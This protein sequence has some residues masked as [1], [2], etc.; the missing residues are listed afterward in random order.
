MDVHISKVIH[1]VTNIASIKSN[2]SILEI[3]GPPDLVNKDSDPKKLKKILEDD[4]II[5]DLRTNPNSIYRNTLK[6]SDIILLINFCLFPNK[7]L[8]K[9]SKTDKRYPYYSSLLL[10]SQAGLLFNKSVKDL[11]KSNDMENKEE[12][13]NNYLKDDKNENLKKNNISCDK[14]E[15]EILNKS[16]ELYNYSNFGQLNEDFFDQNNL[17]NSMEQ[18]EVF[19]E[20]F[21]SFKKEYEN[22]IDEK[23]VNISDTDIQKYSICPKQITQYDEDE[24]EIIN[25][26]LDAIFKILD[27]KD[28]LEE[29]YWGYFQTL[30]NY[31]LNNDSNIIIEYLFREPNL[32]IKKFYKH[33]N[34]IAVK[35]IM[36]NIL[37]IICDNEEKEKDISNSKYNIIIKDLLNELDD[38]E[39][40]LGKFEV[41]CELITNTLINNSE[42]QLIKLIFND[43]LMSIFEKIINKIINNGN[44]EKLR[45]ILKLLCQLNNIILNSFNESPYFKNNIN[46]IDISINEPIKTNNYEYQYYSKKI[47]S[48]KNIFNAY[49]CNI[50]SYLCSLNNLFNLIKDDIINRR[51]ESKNLNK[52]N[53][54][55]SINYNKPNK[56]FGLTNLCECKFIL[57][58]LKL[59]IYSFYSIEKFDKQNIK[60]FNNKKIYKNFINYYFDFTQNSLYQNIFI[61][62][63]K[64][65]CNE[66]S[67]DYLV[68]PFLKKY[69]NQNQNKIIYKMKKIIQNKK[70]RLLIGTNIEILKIFYKSSNPYILKHFENS[71]LDNSYKISFLKSLI[72]KLE[73]KLLN[74]YEYSESEIF[75]NDN[76]DKDTFDGN[77][78]KNK[79][80]LKSFIMIV[81]N[82]IKKCKKLEKEFISTSN[83]EEIDEK[84]KKKIVQENIEINGNKYSIEE[85]RNIVMKMKENTF[86]IEYKVNQIELDEENTKE[87]ENSSEG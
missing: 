14:K 87:E 26:I 61:E 83:N 59:Y 77:D 72:P 16:Q 3:T 63:L 81:E 46:L 43:N 67:P 49:K 4:D 31:M 1:N 79:P 29:T 80:K 30:V 37:N 69:K 40:K 47:I 10:C 5:N 24:K 17:N 54:S 38:N 64:L 6:T 18:G 52:I 45:G 34:E 68:E 33:L 48:N 74:N 42:K 56:E 53:N 85:E 62:I 78:E 32:I 71:E 41:I 55:N 25:N 7:D 23:Y 60:Y 76:E 75:N 70:Q 66:R 58:C 9:K 11:K 22:E 21:S 39:S 86:E 13:K 28:I 27:Y 82:F 19:D 15:I 12:N 36:E 65:I 57:S 51:K 44:N 84:I 20:Y 2:N 8:D 50:K 35:N 73:T